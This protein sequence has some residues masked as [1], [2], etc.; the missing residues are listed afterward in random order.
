[1]FDVVLVLNEIFNY[2][3]VTSSKDSHNKARVQLAVVQDGV[4][5]ILLV[6][7]GAYRQWYV[8]SLHHPTPHCVHVMRNLSPSQIGHHILYANTV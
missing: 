8:Y 7:H 1:M 6:N 4:Q 3:T 2:I 5:A